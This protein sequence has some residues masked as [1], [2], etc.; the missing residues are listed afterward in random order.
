VTLYAHAVEKPHSS[1]P[2]V[3][4]IL[5][6]SSSKPIEVMRAAMPDAAGQVAFPAARGGDR[7]MAASATGERR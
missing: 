6:L 5:S 1:E 4:R 2:A 7:G 3:T